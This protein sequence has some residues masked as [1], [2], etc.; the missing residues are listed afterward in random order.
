MPTVAPAIK[1]IATEGKVE[2]KSWQNL[3]N[4]DNQFLIFNN[5][6]S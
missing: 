6:L 5:L 4:L 2:A 1:Q 3:P